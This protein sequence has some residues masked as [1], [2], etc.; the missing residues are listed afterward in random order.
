MGMKIHGLG[1]LK[2]PVPL[3]AGLKRDSPPLADSKCKVFEPSYCSSLANPAAPLKRDLRFA[4]TSYGECARWSIFNPVKPIFRCLALRINAG[5]TVTKFPPGLGPNE[6]VL[7]PPSY[8][9]PVL[10]QWHLMPP[11]V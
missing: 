7:T 8:S 10:P 9:G 1:K 6:G 5:G 2:L 4:T 11:A 3:L